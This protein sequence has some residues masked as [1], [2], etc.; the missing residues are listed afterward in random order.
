MPDGDIFVLKSGNLGGDCKSDTVNCNLCS[1][2]RDSYNLGTIRSKIFFRISNI[3]V[4][5]PHA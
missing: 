4:P 5:C 3:S 2:S 1:V